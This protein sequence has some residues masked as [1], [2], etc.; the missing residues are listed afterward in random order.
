[1]KREGL[2]NPRDE[3]KLGALLGQ[4]QLDAPIL[5]QPALEIHPRF[6]QYLP[7]RCDDTSEGVAS[8]DSAIIVLC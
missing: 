1:M 3:V 2:V 8:N 5:P 7:H 6:F 4:V